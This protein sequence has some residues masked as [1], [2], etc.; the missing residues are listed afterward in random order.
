MGQVQN[1]K[2]VALMMTSLPILVYAQLQFGT[3]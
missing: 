2:V 1:P 3:Y